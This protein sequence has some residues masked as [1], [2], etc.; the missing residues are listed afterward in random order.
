MNPQDFINTLFVDREDHEHV[1]ISEGIPKLDGDGVW[2]NNMTAEARLFRR[3]S[4]ESS[5]RAIYYC[6]CTVDGEKNDKGRV[7]RGRANLI[8]PHVLVLDDIGQKTDAPPVEPTYKIE[9]SPGSFQWGYALVETTA[10]D[11]GRFEALCSAIFELGFGD[12]GAGGSYRVVRVPGSAN[13]KP[14]REGFLST[15]THWEPNIAWTLAEL[16]EDFSLDLNALPVEDKS[17]PGVSSLVGGAVAVEGIDPLLSWLSDAGHV[18]SDSGGDWVDVVCPWAELHTTGSNTAGY[19]PLGRGDGEWVQTRAFKCQHEHCNDKRY[20]DFVE[21]MSK[22]GAPYCGGYDPLPWL[23]A[24]YTYVG[25]GQKVADMVIRK[26]DERDWIWD[27]ADWAKTNP[28]KIPGADGKMI[29]VATAWLNHPATTKVATTVHYPTLPS[30]DVGIVKGAQDKLNT[31]RPPNWKATPVGVEPEI[32]LE[33]VSWLVPDAGERGVFLDWLAYKI[34]N[35]R[36]RSYAVVMIA[37]GYGVGRSWLKDMLLKMTQGGVNTASLPQLIGEGTQA[38]KNYND[39]MA[40]CQFLCIEEAREALDR[41]VF[42]RG[43]EELKLAIDTRTRDVRVNP[44]FGKMRMETIY[45]NALIFSN[46]ADAMVI[47]EDD[48]RLFVIENPSEMNTPE[49]YEKLNGALGTDFEARALYWW[50]LRRDVSS[51]DYVYPPMTPGKIRMIADNRSPRDLIMEY[52]AETWPS[53]LIARSSLKSAVLMSANTLELD[54]NVDRLAAEIWKKFGSLDPA[55]KNGIR[56]YFEKKQVE[57][58]AVRTREKWLEGVKILGKNE[59][60]KE[61]QASTKAK[62]VVSNVASTAD[63]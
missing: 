54:V 50:L 56:I 33:H 63:S 45:F 24:R 52:L 44:K 12:A 39:W 1:C 4:P 41:A 14:G 51:Y 60:L 53:D 25:M 8:R 36:S 23:Q 31:Y 20:S 6:V 43:Y 46:H 26:S 32:F 37:E 55:S 18:V 35:P 17:G 16:A 7:M 30:E 5:P 27:Y 9:T 40:G 57:V 28:G 59:I 3:W 13:L 19:S 62:L 2:F 29:P 58:R 48:R 21:R 38:D 47:P 34:Q 10:D 49:Y 42:Y 11:L 15:V 61:L 22:S